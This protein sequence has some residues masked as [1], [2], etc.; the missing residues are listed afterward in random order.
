LHIFIFL[1]YL[2]TD[3]ITAYTVNP[4]KETK[5][6]VATKELL[7]HFRTVALSANIH[8]FLTQKA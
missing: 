3:D 2:T 5:K 7:Q 8:H 1:I 4:S 6:P